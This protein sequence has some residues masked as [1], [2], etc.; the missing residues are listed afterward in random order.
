MAYYQAGDV[1][2]FDDN[3]EEREGE[4]SYRDYLFLNASENEVIIYD[5]ENELINRKRN[6]K[7][8]IMDLEVGFI[9]PIFRAE[10]EPYRA[11]L[12]FMQK[13][14]KNNNKI[15]KKLSYDIYKLKEQMIQGVM[16]KS[17]FY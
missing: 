9:P 2:E 6:K 8:I 1:E 14:R 3:V 11:A 7:R 5:K 17:A 12:N 16:I 13:A 4:M 10:P 15:I